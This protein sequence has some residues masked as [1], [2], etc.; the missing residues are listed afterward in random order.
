MERLVQGV[1]D[2]VASIARAVYGSAD[3][4]SM[5][6]FTTVI[7]A[8]GLE[9][10]PMKRVTMYRDDFVAGYLLYAHL[11]TDNPDLA[12]VITLSTRETESIVVTPRMLYELGYTI[13]GRSRMVL[14]N[15][16]PNMQVGSR[17]VISLDPGPPGIAFSGGIRIELVNNSSEKARVRSMIAHAYLLK[18]HLSDAARVG[19]GQRLTGRGRLPSMI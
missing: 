7:N 12:L 11:D 10:E 17:Y 18:S 13:D 9:I 3:F 14:T 1:A 19:L 4:L 5:F 16:D 15:F 6:E 8:R 2:A